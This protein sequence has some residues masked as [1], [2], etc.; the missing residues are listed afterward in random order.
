[1]PNPNDNKY[2]IPTL[3]S[4]TTFYDWVNHYN[5]NVVG[6]LNNIK[7]YNGLSGDGVNL[8][9]GTTAENDPDGG[10]TTGSDL[11]AGVFR[12]SI[13]DTI[14]KGV[15]FYGDLSVNG[16]LKFNTDLTEI[17]NTRMRVYGQTAGFTFGDVVRCATG[18]ITYA[19]ADGK[20]RSEAIG[21]VTGITFSEV[22]TWNP[23]LN[24][25]EVATSG[26]VEGV[27]KSTGGA[28]LSPGCSYFLSAS[29]AGGLTATEPI[30]SGQV[31]K[32]MVIGITYDDG[33]STGANA[34]SK[35]VVVNY[36]GQYLSTGLSGSVA[37]AT[38]NSNMFTVQLTGA[39]DTHTLTNGK[40]VGFR[41][42]IEGGYNGWFE[43]TNNYE[44]LE[45]AVGI[46]VNKFEFGGGQ[47]IQVIGSGLI[48]NYNNLNNSYGL[49]YIGV[50]GLLTGIP[51]GGAVKPFAFVWEQGGDFKAFVIN[52]NHTGEY[53]D[54]AANAQARSSG[55]GGGFAGNYRL[56][57]N[58]GATYG[59]A[60]QP[61]LLI[62]GGFDIW[63]RGI[64]TLPYG[65]TGNTYL[66][67]KWLRIDGITGKYYQGSNYYGGA[68]NIE[69]VP[70]AQPVIG[71]EGDPTYYLRSQHRVNGYSGG[72]GDHIYLVNRLENNETLAGEDVTLSFY[73]KASV[74]GSTM[75]FIVS[76][77]DGN[78]KRNTPIGKWVDGA[79]YNDGLV[80]LGTVWQKHSIGFSVPSVDT[81]SSDSYVDIGFDVTNTNSQLD[82]AQVK[83]E[84]GYVPTIFE[85]TDH[86]LELNKCK[87]Y[88]QRSYS[89]N[90]ETHTQTMRGGVIVDPTAIHILASPSFF[91]YYRFPVD[92]R[93]PPNVS[94]FSPESGH[95]GD[96]Y[97]ETA[98]TDMRLSSGTQTNGNVRSAPTGVDTVRFELITED[99][100]R[101]FLNS[102]VLQWDDIH[103]HY[104]ADADFSADDRVVS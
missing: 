37:G 102:G 22:D 87:R 76:Q 4:T 97:N 24:Y 71:I 52:Q 11:D 36:R 25:I 29:E 104:V 47:Y 88:Y 75:G 43:Y 83:L 45:H 2:Q 61:N 33:D 38:A 3:T 56:G 95:T 82:L 72:A 50:D 94:F 40:V 14:N 89:L 46:V 20:T 7:V 91:D 48:D 93:T 99:G 10:A 15:T 51:P 53:D 26:V 23:N 17:P 30:V 67:D 34:K 98:N 39:P 65:S 13:A 66:A 21:I 85:P 77:Y 70:F 73:A 31:S 63:Q 103:L 96:A 49:Q 90:Q 27:F 8:T 19:Q 12:V 9:L 44:N 18:G 81:T 54:P 79:T 92:M 59:Q 69:R 28:T 6:K 62:N 55:G 16:E 68:P 64:G 84:R 58:A 78:S 1:M 35:V 32:P 74:T 100:F 41:P 57:N 60:I 5:Q 101:V 42:G 86:R 80:R